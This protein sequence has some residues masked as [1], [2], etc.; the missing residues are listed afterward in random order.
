MWNSGRGRETYSSRTTAGIHDSTCQ[1]QKTLSLQRMAA[2]PNMSNG[3]NHDAALL[4]WPTE[5]VWGH[6]EVSLPLFNSQPKSKHLLIRQKIVSNLLLYW[7]IRETVTLSLSP[8]AVL[9]A[10]YSASMSWAYY[11]I[12]QSEHTLTHT[13]KQKTHKVRCTDL[14]W[15]GLDLAT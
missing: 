8:V 12:P 5:S 9:R 7:Q 6:L 3:K 2:S 11:N 15:M 10:S 14:K 13:Q 1:V 4:S